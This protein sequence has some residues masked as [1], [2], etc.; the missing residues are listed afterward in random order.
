VVP[1]YFYNAREN[2]L[3]D[4]QSTHGQWDHWDRCERALAVLSGPA[5]AHRQFVALARRAY[6]LD[7][8]GQTAEPPQ[9][10][11]LAKL[12]SFASYIAPIPAQRRARQAQRAANCG[13][14]D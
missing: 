9:R 13:R 10:G 12:H 6:R 3:W 5:G 2:L 8:L 14:L 4:F 11:W 7:R 1:V